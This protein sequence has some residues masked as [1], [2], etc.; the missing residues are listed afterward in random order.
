[1]ADPI[2]QIAIWVAQT[3]LTYGATYGSSALFAVAVAATV[4][5]TASAISMLGGQSGPKASD[6]QQTLQQPVPHRRRV[7]GKALLGGYVI[8]WD[9]VS[10]KFY[11]LIALAAHE[12]ASVLEVWV[13]DRRVTLDGSGFVTSVNYPLNAD[14]DQ[15][16]SDGVYIIQVITRLGT[17]V[18]AAMSRLITAFPGIWTSDH[19]GLG[20]ADALIVQQSVKQEH[21]QRCYPGGA[22][23]LR[24][25][26]EGA[27]VK[28]PRNL[29]NPAAWSDNAVQ[30]IRDYLTHPDG[31]R[32]DEEFFD[33]GLALPITQANA[34]ICDEL[35]PLK[36]GGSE[37]R[38]RL[39]GFYDFNEEPRSVLTRF[40]AACGGWVEPQRD[41]TVAIRVGAWEEPDVTIRS[42]HIL[43]YEVQHW[44]GEF[45][46]VN[47]IRA[48]F[49]DPNNS[50]QD[51]ESLPWRDEEDILR[52][53]Y[54]RPVTIDARHSPAFGQTRRIQKVAAHEA[55][56]EWQL[57]L[58]TNAYGLLAR[59][60]RFIRLQIDELGLDINVRVTSFSA[61]TRTGRCAMSV[62]S[63]GSEAYEWDADTEEGDQPAAP[64]DTSNEGAIED[65][66][67]LTV[68]V[69]TRTVSG[70]VVGAVMVMSCDL[71]SDRDDLSARFEYQVDGDSQWT[72]VPPGTNSFRVET[73]F[74]A[75]GTYNAR[76]SLIGPGGTQS[77]TYDTVDL[78]VV[79]P[80][81]TA[82]AEPT[83]LAAH[84]GSPAVSV[85]V[86]FTAPN[87]GNFY[88]A[89]VYRNTTAT[90]G[91][92]TDIS[93]PVYG[94]PNQAMSFTDSSPGT[95]TKYYW[96]TAENASGADSSPEGP[97]SVTI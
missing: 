85:L 55:S 9:S 92:A 1:M 50:Y 31:W 26:I 32:I 79:S 90:F 84:V 58:A 57:T 71:P 52:R 13:G 7:Y 44:P 64:P 82:P 46:V 48:G 19:K 35:V 30:V 66:T 5:A 12:I 62:A 70:S 72:Q 94:S 16:T 23:G 93:G 80:T 18:Q 4:V 41:G 63:F 74:V 3:A 21:F 88:A 24:C 61:D 45:D 86:S 77:P 54:A 51:A 75:D 2:S 36:A 10:G 83:G 56:P 39:W 97:V 15:F 43:G 34:T 96:V 28:D 87:S 14:P 68:D 22:Q 40:L 73:G 6:G 76:V 27:K 67:G 42:E 95:G 47:E 78:I 59:N 89:R 53:G 33:T 37:K 65:P 69:E 20:I 25:L 8:F 17:D 29:A 38:Y 49:T 81:T 91:T 11:S 60:K